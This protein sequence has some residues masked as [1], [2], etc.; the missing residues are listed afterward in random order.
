MLYGYCNR[1]LKLPGNR[2]DF[3]DSRGGLKREVRP[4]ARGNLYPKQDENDSF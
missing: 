4:L 1:D 3:V 2:F